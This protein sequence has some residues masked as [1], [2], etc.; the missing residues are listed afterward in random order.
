MRFQ[1][2]DR[3]TACEPGRS[4]KAVKLLTGGEEYLGDHFPG[5][6]VMPG[7][8]MLQALAEAASWLVRATDDFAQSVIVLREV[9]SVKY[10]TFL[11]PGQALELSVEWAGRTGGLTSFKGKGESAAGNNVTAQFAL[12]AYNLADRDP[13]WADRDAQ[14]ARHWRERWRL[15]NHGRQG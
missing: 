14:L 2:V 6:P 5:F 1:L 15:L 3:I 10:G 11:Q 4:L 12:A 9:K 7:V 13:A 8:L